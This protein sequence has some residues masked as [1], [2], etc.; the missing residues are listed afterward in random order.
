VAGVGAVVAGV[1]PEEGVLDGVDGAVVVDGV[2]PGDG[3]VVVVEGVPVVVPGVAGVAPGVAVV[4]PG[5][6]VVVV[7]GV[8]VG[9]AVGEDVVVLVGVGVGV[10]V[11]EGV[12]GV[13]LES[14]QEV[15]VAPST[16]PV[17]LTTLVKLASLSST[18]LVPST[19]K[20][21]MPLLML[22]YTSMMAVMF[23]WHEERRISVS[24]GSQQG[25]GRTKRDS[26]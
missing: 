24:N 16:A 10:A 26:R 17:S 7:V 12:V 18:C 25:N 15:S 9:V 1:S 11:G 13:E 19:K 4:V 20:V 2:D 8:A 23:C 22:S 3:A 5:V 21:E 6:E 14:S